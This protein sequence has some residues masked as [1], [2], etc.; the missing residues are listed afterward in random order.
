MNEAIRDERD[1]MLDAW[2]TDRSGALAYLHS[3]GT[4]WLETVRGDRWPDGS[5]VGPH[6]TKAAAIRAYL[7]RRA[8]LLRKAALTAE[9]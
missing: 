5:I 8:D 6:P 2:P 1:A 9:A 4:W 7:A 3:D